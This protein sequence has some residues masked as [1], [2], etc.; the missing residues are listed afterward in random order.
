MRGNESELAVY[1]LSKG[2][3]P[4]NVRVLKGIKRALKQQPACHTTHP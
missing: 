4:Y 2:N 1:Y 3:I